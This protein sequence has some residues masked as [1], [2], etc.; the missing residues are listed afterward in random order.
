MSNESS[1]NFVNV[2]ITRDVSRNALGENCEMFV[3]MKTK[4]GLIKMS[5]LLIKMSVL[6]IKKNKE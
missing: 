3:N 5:V 4:Q 1:D 2:R 6:L